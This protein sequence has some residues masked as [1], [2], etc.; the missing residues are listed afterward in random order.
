MDRIPESIL[1]KHRPEVEG[2]TIYGIPITSMTVDELQ[3]MLVMAGK[4]ELAARQR[5]TDKLDL[6]CQLR[7]G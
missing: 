7:T 3:C 6:L 1:A 2:M 4:A 5:G